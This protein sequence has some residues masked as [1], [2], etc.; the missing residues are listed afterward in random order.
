MDR[1]GN[2]RQ[3]RR[4]G[5]RGISG[6]AHRGGRELQAHIAEIQA[7]Q[8]EHNAALHQIDHSHI[9]PLRIA[10]RYAGVIRRKAASNGNAIQGDGQQ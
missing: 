4:I 3:H 6:S 8:E 9:P 2:C 1:S 10:E 5:N 7:E